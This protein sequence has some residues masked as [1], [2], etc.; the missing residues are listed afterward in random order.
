MM[1]FTSMDLLWHHLLGA[2]QFLQVA[3]TSYGTWHTYHI[4]NFHALR[5]KLEIHFLGDAHDVSSFR[6]H[7]S[8]TYGRLYNL[9]PSWRLLGD[10]A[11]GFVVR[12]SHCSSY[13]VV[14]YLDCSIPLA[15][16]LLFNV[17][18]NKKGVVGLGVGRSFLSSEDGIRLRW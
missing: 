4:I 16:Y 5:S 2:K 12:T 3:G 7:F 11:K 15:F 10:T 13:G 18:N 9:K 17:T 1:K 14:L 8:G 6:R